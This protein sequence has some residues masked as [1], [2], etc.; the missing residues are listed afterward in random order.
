ME[1]EEEG[2]SV[3]ISTTMPIVS[4]SLSLQLEDGALLWGRDSSARWLIVMFADVF[5]WGQSPRLPSSF[6]VSTLLL[7]VVA[8]LCCCCSCFLVVEVAAAE[9]AAAAAAALPASGIH[10][11]R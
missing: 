6:C 4:R 5:A 11:R 3:S 2:G 7:A 1:E 8:G 10:R 9:V